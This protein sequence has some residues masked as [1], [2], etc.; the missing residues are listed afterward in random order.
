MNTPCTQTGVQR[1]V[2]ILSQSITSFKHS[3]DIIL[4]NKIIPHE[5][6]CF[7]LQLLK[8]RIGIAWE[9]VFTDFGFKRTR[10]NSCP[11]GG[12][13]YDLYNHTSK[14]V[15]ELKNNY[16]SDS[17]KAKRYTHNKLKL[18]KRRNP[19]Y[20]VIYGAINYKNSIGKLKVKDNVLYIYGDLLLNRFLGNRKNYVIR[21]LRNAITFIY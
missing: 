21:R 4:K 20:K 12:C 8:Q 17:G 19:T 13:V 16:N 14:I 11:R 9:H 1:A 7:E 6:D 18:F 3:N 10:I 2:Q 15:I 5:R